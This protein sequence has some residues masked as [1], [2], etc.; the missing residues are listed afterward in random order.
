LKM[1]KHFSKITFDIECNGLDPDTIWC[2]VIKEYKGNTRIFRHDDNNIKEGV[3]MLMQADTLIGHNIIGFDIPVLNKLYDIDLFKDKEIIDTLTMS[4]LFNPIREGGHGLESWGY[5]LK[6]YKGDPP[7]EWDEFDPRMV[8]YCEQDV[9]LNEALYDKLVLDGSTFSNQSIEVEHEVSKILQRQEQHGFFFNEKKGAELLAVLKTRMREVEDEVHKVFKPR[10]VDV[11][12][13]T[14][15]LKQDGELS[16]SG[17]TKYEYDEIKLTDNIKPFMRKKLQE[18]NLGSRKQIGEYL[19]DFGWKPRRFTPTGQPIIDEGTLK[20]IDHIPEAKLI[21]EFLLLQKRIAQ[22]DSWFAVVKDSRVHGRVFCIGA[23]TNRMSHRSPNLAQVPSLKSEY[24]KECRACWSVPEGYKLVGIDAAGLELR[25]LAHY[26]RDDEYTNELVNGDIH[27]RNQEIAGLKTRDNAK[28]FIYA[29]M[30]GAGDAKL[31][32][33]V[34]GSRATGKK[35]KQ[36]FLNNLPSFK[37]LKSKVEQASQRGYL[38]GLDGRKIL[39]RHEHASLNTLLQS[40]GA[41]VMKIALVMLDTLAKEEKLDYHFV[42]NVHD[43]W[44]VEVSD[45]DSERFGELGVKAIQEAGK[46]LKL[47]CPLDGEYK[48]GDS[49]DATH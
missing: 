22:I 10:W 48:I 21:A 3:D 37:I 24:G 12:L 14:P 25:M 2:I 47:R 33:V 38:L 19:T 20:K 32:E 34:G 26:M 44:Q 27:S 43:E 23:I 39:V 16:K 6:I 28:S 17:L 15:K 49:W 18:F 31:G 29:L 1:K 40:A 9:I 11:K 13:V 5:R 41:I 30:Y 45:K 36:Q 35:L 42:A 4:R 46:Y 8:P 7:A